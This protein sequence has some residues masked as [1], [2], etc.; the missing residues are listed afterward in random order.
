MNGSGGP[1]PALPS[2]PTPFGT[3]ART[4]YAVSGPDG[5]C[6]LTE[7]GRAAICNEGI[8]DLARTTFDA[9]AGRWCVD[10]G[11]YLRYLRAGES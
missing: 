2:G 10:C 1:L 9:A 6:H 5:V 3:P 11:Q 4:M 8:T 7:H